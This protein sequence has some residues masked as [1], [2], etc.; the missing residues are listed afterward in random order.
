[1]ITISYSA[2]TYEIYA[3]F[4]AD[5]ERDTQSFDVIK[6]VNV[7]SLKTSIRNILMTRQGTRRMQ[8]RFG[9]DL[10]GKLFEPLTSTTAKEIGEIIVEQINMWD[11]DVLVEK[12]L[13]K[14]DED[15]H[16]YDALIY[17]S[18]RTASIGTSTIKFVL[19]QR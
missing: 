3:D 9:A 11:P 2:G 1:M 15:N 12:V 10:E 5:M 17:F 6:D 19:E 16:R 18:A 13:M 8:P 14:I 7:E 4:D